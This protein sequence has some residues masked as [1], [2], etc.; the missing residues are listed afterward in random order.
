M[1]KAKVIY[2]IKITSIIILLISLSAFNSLFG[3]LKLVLKNDNELNNRF[4]NYKKLGVTKCIVQS[5][6]FE[7]HQRTDNFEIIEETTIDYAENVMTVKKFEPV[8]SL[9][10]YRFNEDNKISES[11]FMKDTVVT[12]KIV[13]K[14]NKG[15][16]QFE[17][18]Y[19]G[20]DYSFTIEYKYDEY[21]RVNKQHT[22][23]KDKNVV[24][25]SLIFYDDEGNLI[26]EEKTDIDG[27][28]QTIYEYKYINRNVV[29]EA[30][31]YPTLKT[32][33]RTV[34]KYD[35]LN[36]LIQITEFS[37]TGAVYQI[38]KLKYDDKNQIIEEERFD[39]N[40]NILSRTNYSYTKDGLLSEKSLDDFE[41]TLEYFYKYV[42][43]FK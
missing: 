19:L 37:S 23:D 25:T 12:S 20:N 35:G 24:S 29:E 41:E 9:E 17:E 11:I 33:T 15:Y 34:Y 39:K 32:E 1:N 5:F 22:Y 28:F 27:Y 4:L 2:N 40:N 7:D 36:R 6:D 13:C 26:R 42:Y 10:I 30:I 16:K 18:Y 21:G 38:T 3:Q 8:K 31:L 43:E 14:Y